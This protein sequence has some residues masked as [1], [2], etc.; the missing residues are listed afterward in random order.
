MV[1]RDES[2]TAAVCEGVFDYQM[3]VV[4]NM[5]EMRKRKKRSDKCF[6]STLILIAAPVC[7]RSAQCEQKYPRPD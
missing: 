3:S 4:I 7:A 5:I 2:E 1:G 6:D